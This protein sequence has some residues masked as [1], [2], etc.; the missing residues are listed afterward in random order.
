MM[1]TLVNENNGHKKKFDKSLAERYLIKGEELKTR[2]GSD[3]KYWVLPD[4][5][6]YYFDNGSLFKKKNNEG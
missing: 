3:I 4:N 5:S 1:I 2:I 6:K